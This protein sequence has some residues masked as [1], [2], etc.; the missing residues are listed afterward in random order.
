M[1]TTYISFEK[2]SVAFGVSMK[3]SD[4]AKPTK[5]DAKAFAKET[6]GAYFQMTQFSGGT[7]F[8]S[9]TAGRT[10]EKV[11]VPAISAFATLAEQSQ[12]LS[13]AW[14]I[15]L[16]DGMACLQILD[17]RTPYSDEIMLSSEI[18]AAIKNKYS[19]LQLRDSFSVHIT[20]GFGGEI[21]ALF[22][23]AHILS[24]EDVLSRADIKTLKL[25]VLADYQLTVILS[26]CVVG[27]F[28]YLGYGYWQNQQEKAA[29]QSLTSTKPAVDPAKEYEANVDRLL[30][31]AGFTGLDAITEMEK[32][33]HVTETSKAG[34]VMDNISCSATQCTE[35]WKLKNGTHTSLSSEFKNQVSFN[36][37]QKTATHN[38]VISGKVGPVLR[39]SLSTFAELE[40]TLN[41]NVQLLSE[42]TSLKLTLGQPGVFGLTKD[43][44]IEQIPPD[45]LVRSGAFEISGPVGIG[46]ELIKKLPNNVAVRSYSITQL[47]RE[48]DAAF[49]L[50]GEYFVK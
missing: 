34:W 28:G 27:M 31:S 6:R 20:P 14:I 11:I 10:L 3:T 45:K 46:N 35:I 44:K 50:K 47:Q 41:E 29:V 37:D 8:F 43:Q 33:F 38:Q 24:V 30:A 13:H 12:E 21:S 2:M 4:K 25:Q 9:A 26:V 7:K 16:S 19:E 23:D 48:A 22:P 15:N 39:Q 18:P 17:N 1:A 32:T 49:S 36:P 5:S 40:R 42:V